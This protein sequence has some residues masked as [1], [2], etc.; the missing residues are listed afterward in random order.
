MRFALLLASFL[1]SLIGCGRIDQVVGKQLHEAD[2]FADPTEKNFASWSP[3]WLKGQWLVTIGDPVHSPP[4][5][6][7]WRSTV[8]SSL[9]RTMGL[10]PGSSVW[11]EAGSA[12]NS[13]LQLSFETLG[14]A[15]LPQLLN[16]MNE[17]PLGFMFVT[18]KNPNAFLSSFAPQGRFKDL[19]GGNG[20]SPL[21]Q[22]F[23]WQKSSLES[24]PGV[25]WAE[26]NLESQLFQSPTS[27]PGYTPPPELGTT[28][29]MAEIFKRIGA[30]KAYE[31]VFDKNLSLSE[32]NV[33]VLDTGVDSQHPDLKANIFSNPREVAGNGIDDDGNC[34]IDDIHGIDATVECSKDAGV[35]PKPGSADLGGPGKPCPTGAS[36]GSASRQQD[37][38]LTTN[39]GHGSHVAGIIASKHGGNLSTLGVCPSCKIISVRVSERCLQPDTAASGECVKPT[40]PFDPKERWEVDGGIADTSQIRGLSYLFR[41]RQKDSD[42]K[43]VTNVINMSLGKYFRSRA[44]AYVIRNLERLNIVVVAAAGNDNTDVPSYPAAYASVVSVCATGTALHRGIFGKAVFS[45]FGDWVDICAPGV[46]IY[47]T[48]PGLGSSGQG[49]FDDKSG[50]SQATPFVAGSIGYLLSVYKD[51]KSGA[52]YVRQLKKA[53]NYEK[54][55][56]AEYNALYRAC[57]ANSDVCDHLLGTGFLDL[58][59]A[60]QGREQ[61]TVDEGNGRAVTRG[62]VVSSIGGAGPFFHR[63]AWSSMPIVILAAYLLLKMRRLFSK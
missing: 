46:D 23:L 9:L 18:L 43:L 57:Y 32:V 4:P 42:D 59:A 40:S 52:A 2:D 11:E 41:L 54:L 34:H 44:M 51:V 3:T 56:S 6:E 12:L 24:I 49:N 39:C 8:Q 61:T 35:D 63:T 15:T 33:A 55:Y 62:C 14:F 20:K 28:S 50:T 10:N 47:S 16:S 21:H 36:A 38:G 45:N 30:D 7:A 27:R 22:S 53:A 1:F 58:G 26:P 13:Q 48:V 60:V 29:A 17:P 5:G 37:D 25:V 31:T 19:F